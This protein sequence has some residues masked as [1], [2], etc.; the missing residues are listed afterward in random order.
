MAGGAPV[1]LVMTANYEWPTATNAMPLNL[2][3]TGRGSIVLY[4]QA[5]AAEVHGGAKGLHDLF[6]TKARKVLQY[7]EGSLP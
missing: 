3:G 4:N 7:S 5:S 1:Q 2:I 6:A